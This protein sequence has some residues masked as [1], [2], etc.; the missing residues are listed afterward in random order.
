MDGTFRTGQTDEGAHRTLRVAAPA[1][2]Q[3]LVGQK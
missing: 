3:V 2:G 1:V